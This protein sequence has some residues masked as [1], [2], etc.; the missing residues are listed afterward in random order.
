MNNLHCSMFYSKKKK[1]E[2]ECYGIYLFI[3]IKYIFYLYFLYIVKH[4]F[5]H[6]MVNI[7]QF[8]S[9]SR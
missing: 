8:K 1:I 2:R 4:F 6:I 9:N 7:Y 5:F 3:I